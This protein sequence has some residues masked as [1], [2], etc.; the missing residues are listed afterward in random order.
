VPGGFFVMLP[1]VLDDDEDDARR[2]A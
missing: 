1:Q 2:S